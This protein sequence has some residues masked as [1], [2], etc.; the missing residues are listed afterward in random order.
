MKTLLFAGLVLTCVTA[1]ALAASDHALEEALNQ[2]YLG[3]TLTLRHPVEKG[4]QKYD[5]AGT[6]LSGGSEGPWTLYGGMNILKISLKL[7]RLRLEGNRVYFIYDPRQTAMSYVPD[8]DSRLKLEVLLQHPCASLGEATVIIRRIFSITDEDLLDS[9]PIFWKSF[10]AKRTGLKWDGESHA[11]S[12]TD[13]LRKVLS[14]NKTNIYNLRGG[15]GVSPP[16]AVY[17]PVPSFTRQALSHRFQGVVVLSAIVDQ[18]GKVQRPQIVRA[19]G[20]GLD[21]QAIEA[22]KS[23]KFEPGMRDGKPVN[24]EMLL[25]VAFNL[26]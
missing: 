17:T 14:E 16:R 4:S 10:I 2:Q 26:Q 18:K 24:I 8:K 19:L 12:H 23:W 5:S 22:M 21:E 13:S 9:V 7:D 20:M 15:E 6:P 11:E 25:E 1:P 3:Q